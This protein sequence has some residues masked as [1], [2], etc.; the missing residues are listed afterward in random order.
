MRSQA[1][2]EALRR[3]VER[4][5]IASRQTKYPMKKITLPFRD[6]ADTYSAEVI[7][8]IEAG[9]T[10]DSHEDDNSMIVMTFASKAKA[11]AFKRE[12]GLDADDA[13][14]AEADPVDDTP[15]E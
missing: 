6:Y 5:I 8:A 2:T 14:Q 13:T 4:V 10:S 3:S 7:A 12:V 11:D 1:L 9:A 15:T